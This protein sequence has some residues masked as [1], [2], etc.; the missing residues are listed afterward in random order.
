MYTKEIHELEIIYTEKLYSKNIPIFFLEYA[1]ACLEVI[2]KSDIGADDFQKVFLL[3][4]NKPQF[5]GATCFNLLNDGL[6]IVLH[7]YEQF[8]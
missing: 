8:V 2:Q 6:P 5:L 3:L 4:K 7:H 1:M